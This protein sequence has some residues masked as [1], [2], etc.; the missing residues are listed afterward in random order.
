MAV[1]FFRIHNLQGWGW[2][3]PRAGTGGTR[4]GGRQYQPSK[5]LDKNPLGKPS[6][7]KNGRMGPSRL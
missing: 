3:N 2:G 1:I 6:S 4:P 7:G 5:T